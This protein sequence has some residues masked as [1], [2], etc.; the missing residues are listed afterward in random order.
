MTIELPWPPSVNRY[1][2]KWRNR[3]VLSGDARDYREMVANLWMV[4]RWP[5]LQQ[6]RVFLHS[7]AHPPCRRKRDLDN[8]L[9]SLQDALEYS[10][11][12]LSDEQV[13]DLRVTRG[14]VVEGGKVIVKVGPYLA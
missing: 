14:E 12:F 10:G 7:T 6:Q 5:K 13:D 3:M 11:V 8:I 9:K 2:R 1:W 4:N